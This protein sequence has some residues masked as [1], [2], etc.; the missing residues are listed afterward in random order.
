MYAGRRYPLLQT[1]HWSRMDWAIPMAW[2]ALVTVLYQSGVRLA[3]PWLPISVVGV[4]VAFYLGFKN[5]ESYG[6]LWEARKIYGAIVNASRHWAYSVRD[7]PAATSEGDV[8]GIAERMVHRHVAWMDA[9][10]HQ[11]RELRAWEHHDPQAQ[12]ARNWSVPPESTEDL[13]DVLAPNLSEQELDY[14]LSKI[15]PAAHLLAEQSRDLTELRRQSHIDGFAHV[16]LQWVLQDLMTQQGKAERIKN[17]PFPR[18]YA[19]VNTYFAWLFVLLIPMGMLTT[20]GDLDS[21]Y[22]V[23]LTIPFSTVVSWV[24]LTTD[25]IG[26]WSENPFEGLPNDIP[27]TSMSRGIERDLRQML[28][29]QELPEPRALQGKISF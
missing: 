1:L 27:I 9:L 26:D 16:H 5:S 28:D 14:V 18:Q 7:L 13:R 21:R 25:R 19:T 10:R 4:A 15:N 6:R 3:I 20:F 12:R 2:S 29:E 22:T 8:N 23:W 11:L 17:Y 24:F